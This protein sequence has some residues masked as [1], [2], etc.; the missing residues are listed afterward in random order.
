MADTA[1]VAIVGGGPA[2]AALA[3]R[4]ADAGLETVLFER[5]SKPDWRACGVFSSPLTRDR[6]A[7]L[8]FESREI[9]KL[10]RPIS[11][12][13]LQTT[14]GTSC[15][16]DYRHG[17]ACGF[18]RVRLDGALLDRAR[19]RGVDVRVAS[20]V[21]RVELP[22]AARGLAAITVST[23]DSGAGASSPAHVPRTFRARLVVGADGAASVVSRAA[24]VH[25]TSRFLAR[26][27][28]TFH[29]RDPAAGPDDGRP[30]DGRFVFGLNWYVGIA[31][32]PGQRVNIGIVVPSALDSRGTPASIADRLFADFPPPRHAWIDEPTTDH[33]AVAG[34]LEH[35]VSQAAGP[36]FL[37]I[38]DAIRF[39]D[40]LTGEGLLRAMVSAELAADAIL[41][42]LRGD[43][44]ALAVYD[45]R[46]RNRWRSKDLVS[47]I[48]QLFLTQPRAFDYALRR[49][50]A[51]DALREQLTLVLTDQARATRAIDPRFLGRLLAP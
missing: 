10:H 9:D 46:I 37:L 33:V 32:V 45:R 40:P 12:L 30:M 18:D 17:R 44:S 3:I 28:I 36:G 19:T 2:G 29:R 11:A 22:E 42:S 15:R 5:R 26:M 13:D 21:R 8:G 25:R 35:H 16:I 23:T 24:G 51:R 14:R 38:G 49:L 6:L 48:L 43:Q 47:W 31:P 39:I 7:D 34:R 41:K 27:G 50:A 20:V 4:L 1:D